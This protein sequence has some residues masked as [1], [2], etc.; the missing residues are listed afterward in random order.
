MPVSAEV[1]VIQTSTGFLVIPW[2]CTMKK[3]L[4]QCV[5]GSK[6]QLNK[7]PTSSA[8]P[9]RGLCLVTGMVLSGCKTHESVPV[10]V[11]LLTP[12]NDM[13]GVENVQGPSLVELYF[14]ALF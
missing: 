5:N 8:P 10:P 13:G 2:F 12:L 11:S 7:K 9:S 6:D 1:L 14:L 4:T 3:K